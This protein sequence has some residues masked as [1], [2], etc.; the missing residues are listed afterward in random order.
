MVKQPHCN[1][2]ANAASACCV[3]MPVQRNVTSATQHHVLNSTLALGRKSKAL[4]LSPRALSL[5]SFVLY[6]E[7]EET[8]RF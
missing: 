1:I 7:V 2:R 4:W 6:G 3:N 8:G 5:G